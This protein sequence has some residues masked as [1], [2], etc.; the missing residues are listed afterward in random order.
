MFEGRI[1][2]VVWAFAPSCY[3]AFGNSRGDP[4]FRIVFVIKIFLFD[5]ARNL[6]LKDKQILLHDSRRSSGKSGIINC[7]NLILNIKHIVLNIQS[8][9]RF[10]AG[11]YPF[12]LPCAGLSFEA[13]ALR[14]PLPPGNRNI[15]QRMI[16]DAEVIA[17]GT[18]TSLTSSKTP[19][20]PRKARSER[21]LVDLILSATGGRE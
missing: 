9:G 18:V 6:W 17:I 7:V 10:F 11:L 12:L 2:G 15:F 20:P 14:T 16:Q 21:E 13:E 8:N 3:Q 4:P 19:Q 1:F 5:P